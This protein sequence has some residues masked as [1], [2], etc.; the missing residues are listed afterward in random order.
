MSMATRSQAPASAHSN[1]TYGNQEDSSGRR[2]EAETAVPE[3]E[4]KNEAE[5]NIWNREGCTGQLNPVQTETEAL[6]HIQKGRGSG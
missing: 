1:S 4:I 6:V 5:A 2:A 3:G